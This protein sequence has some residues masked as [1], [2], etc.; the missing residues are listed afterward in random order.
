MA[1]TKAKKLKMARIYDRL[2]RIY[3]KRRR[4]RCGTLLEQLIVSILSSESSENQAFRAFD[5]LRREYVDWNEVR[6]CDEF[7]LAD[8]LRRS[9]VNSGA[10]MLLKNTLEGLLLETSSLQ[11]EVLDAMTSQEVSA[12]LAKIGV[13]KSLAAS[14]LLLDGQ[15]RRPMEAGVPVPIDEGIARLMARAGFASTPR[16]TLQI[17]ECLKTSLPEGEEHNFHRVAARLSREFCGDT[18]NCPGCPVKTD[19]RYTGAKVASPA[20]KAMP[21]PAASDVRYAPTGAARCSRPPSPF[22]HEA[23]ADRRQKLRKLKSLLA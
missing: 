11:P 14:V 1:V 3:G 20:G 10:P 9:G 6:V 7:L 12:L 13:P 8:N 23:E 19:C 2:G 17:H 22:S 4:V 16:A 15:T 18:P 21:A 5:H